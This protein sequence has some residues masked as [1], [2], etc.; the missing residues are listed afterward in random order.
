[1][2]NVFC[3]VPVEIPFRSVIRSD[4][5]MSFFDPRIFSCILWTRIVLVVGSKKCECTIFV[6]I[7][8]FFFVLLNISKVLVAIN[9]YFHLNKPKT[10]VISNFFFFSFVI[11]FCWCRVELSRV[12]LWYRCN[13]I[14]SFNCCRKSTI[15]W[16][17]VELY[18]GD[19]GQ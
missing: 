5:E 17:W 13:N 2:L 6:C 9:K 1:M 11:L 19:V 14:A 8:F 4:F 16:F 3:S 18:G 10:K 12:L 7:I 15:V